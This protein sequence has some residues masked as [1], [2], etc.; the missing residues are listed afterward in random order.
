MAEILC[1]ECEA[2]IDEGFSHCPYCGLTN[3]GATVLGPEDVEYLL[4]IGKRRRIPDQSKP[5]FMLIFG[6]ATLIGLIGFVLIPI[7]IV[8]FV[9]N[10]KET[11]V[12]HEVVY[13]DRVNH[14]FVLYD[15]KDQKVV[16]NPKE[17]KAGFKYKKEKFYYQGKRF[18]VVREEL[19]HHIEEALAEEE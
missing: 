18:G 16:V 8:T 5:V 1:H 14:Q 12:P 4:V 13:H 6:L 7:A 9:K 2:K 15:T 17:F 11:R 10:Q 3:P 19:F